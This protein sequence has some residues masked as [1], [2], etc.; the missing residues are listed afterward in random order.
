MVLP[1]L[2]TEVILN[3]LRYVSPRDL[4]SLRLSSTRFFRIVEQHEH[5]L[6]NSIAISGG[7]GRAPRVL[8]KLKPT[9]GTRSIQKLRVLMQQWNRHQRV[10]QLL[11]VILSH[12]KDIGGSPQLARRGLELLWEYHQALHMESQD[13]AIEGHRTFVRSVTLEELNSLMMTIRACGDV[14]FDI[15]KLERSKP[16]LMEWAE[17]PCAGMNRT[18]WPDPLADMVIVKG[19][20][21]LAEVV[22]E[23][24]PEAL[25]E[26][27]DWKKSVS[28]P[29]MSRLCDE[30]RWKA[31]LAVLGVNGI[32]SG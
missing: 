32:D 31:K 28:K 5:V 10:E 2:A 20:D 4:M 7:L 1:V 17:Q 19:L 12:N 11:P 29:A 13:P 30:Q 16:L 9:V 26:M 6:Y 23:R 24:S 21:F 18:A 27:K 25:D 8:L 22:V 15:Y 14:L 3:I